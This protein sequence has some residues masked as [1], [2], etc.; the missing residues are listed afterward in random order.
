[1]WEQ[2]TEWRG[3][4]NPQ[5]PLDNTASVLPNEIERKTINRLTIHTHDLYQCWLCNRIFLH[6]ASI[7]ARKKK[8]TKV[9]LNT[10]SFIMRFKMIYTK[11]YELFPCIHN[12]IWNWT[13]SKTTNINKFHNWITP[14]E[15]RRARYFQHTPNF[16][17]KTRLS[18]D[19]H[20][21]YIEM[22]RNKHGNEIKKKLNKLF[23]HCAWNARFGND[24]QSERFYVWNLLFVNCVFSI[25]CL[26]FVFRIRFSNHHHRFD[27]S[28]VYRKFTI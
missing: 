9:T 7:L 22:R 11:L 15:K 3:E 2:Q 20:R 24:K 19:C 27:V 23:V 14:N 8:K 10:F 26:W 18:I 6:L 1:M 4:K 5:K 28:S 17:P 21:R 16:V 13:E 25:A 12:S